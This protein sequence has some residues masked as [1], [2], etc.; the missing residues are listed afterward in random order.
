MSGGEHSGGIDIL[1]ESPPRQL[2]LW[3]DSTA[4]K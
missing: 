1:D 3:R 2:K 4:G